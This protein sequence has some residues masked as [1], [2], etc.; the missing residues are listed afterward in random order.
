MVLKV[1]RLNYN[2]CSVPEAARIMLAMPVHHNQADVLVAAPSK[3]IAHGLASAIPNL[4]V[5][6]RSDP[7]FL[8]A[9]GNDVDAL[10]AGG[11]FAVPRVLACKPERSDVVVE[12]RADGR[13][14]VVGRLVR[15]GRF[16][17]RFE[18][19]DV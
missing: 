15:T 16:E 12:L 3:V 1:F 7:G 17:F 4:G 10:I 8:L 13:H 19:G 9:M 5:P 11:Q 18:L 6:R 14:R 2:G